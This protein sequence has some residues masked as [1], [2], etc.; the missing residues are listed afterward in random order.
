MAVTTKN[1][2]KL[3]FL[4]NEGKE[5][6]VSFAY[7]KS[8]ASTSDIKALGTGIITNSDI[9]QKTYLSLEGAQMITTT[10]TD[11]TLPS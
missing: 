1:V 9:F 4:D 7:A 6:P 5:Q 11:L 10:T 3:T 8:N 2:L